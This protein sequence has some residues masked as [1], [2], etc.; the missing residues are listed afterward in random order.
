MIDFHQISGPKSSKQDNFQELCSQ[1]VL[2]EFPDAKPIE[3]IGGDA[4]LD[5][6]KGVSPSRP[7]EVWQ[8]KLFYNPLKQPQKRQIQDSFSK[9]ANKTVLI[10]WIL[11]LPRNL[12][13]SEEEWLQG[14]SNTYPRLGKRSSRVSIEWWGETK[15]RELLLRN[16]DIAFEFFPNLTEQPPEKSLIVHGLS[17]GSRDIEFMLTNLSSNVLIIKKISLEVKSW[18][19]FNIRPG[20]GA[21][22]M[23]YRY[24]VELMPK[25]IGEYLVTSDKFKYSRGDVDSF[26][27]NFSSPPGNKYTT[28]LNFYCS[29]AKTSKEFVVN[30]SDFEILFYNPT[31]SKGMLV[32]VE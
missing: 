13:P 19:P 8:A 16:P 6:Y 26:T 25:Y 1:L 2:R 22:I 30:S 24:E 11:C 31:G 4:G 7:V 9:V 29:D 32:I 27:I 23:T 20:I 5:I 18:E 28:R 17:A 10:R 15:L 3:G 21:R 14:L 12:N